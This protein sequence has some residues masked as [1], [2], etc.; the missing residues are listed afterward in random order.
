MR[1]SEQQD[2]V[3]LPSWLKIPTCTCVRHSCPTRKHVSIANLITELH[4]HI[5]GR[6][7]ARGEVVA[8]GGHRQSVLI[9]F[10]LKDFCQFSP[11]RQ[12][13]RSTSSLSLSLQPL[14]L[15]WLASASF[16]LSR[17]PLQLPSPDPNSVPVVSF[18][19]CT[20]RLSF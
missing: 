7:V 12:V 6:N 5:A 2:S 18:P 17:S 14:F 16:D 20:P 11:S 10:T 3:S 1:G 15:T 9:H 19:V 4:H 8:N 13:F